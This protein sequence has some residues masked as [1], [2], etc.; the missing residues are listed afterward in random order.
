VNEYLAQQGFAVR[1]LN[2]GLPDGFIE[3]G[4]REQL[5]ADCGLDADGIEARVR[6]FAIAATPTAY[7]DVDQAVDCAA[8]CA[9]GHSR[10][11]S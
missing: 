2:L 3:Q 8:D 11:I 5:L 6:G 1:I 4:S 7:A 10:L 9:P